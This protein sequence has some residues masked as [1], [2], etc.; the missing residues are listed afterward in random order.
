[1]RP[2]KKIVLLLLFLLIVFNS[3][4][5]VA[6]AQPVAAEKKWSDWVKS[7]LYSLLSL[8]LI[9]VAF[10]I[11]FENRKPSETIAWILAFIL[12]P[13]FGIILYFLIGRNWRK[14]KLFRQ[15]EIVEMEHI[16]EI[17]HT[18]IEAVRS[19]EQ[20]CGGWMTNK[21][22]LL[23]LVLNNTHSPFTVNNRTE[24]LTNGRQTYGAILE[25]IKKAK[26]HIHLEFYIVRDDGIGKQIQQAL[27]ERAKQ[28]VKVRFMYDGLGSW[29]LSSQYVE[30]LKM[31]G[32]QVAAFLPVRIP[33]MNSKLNYRNH[34]K[35][36]VIDGSIGF[37]GG[38]NIGDEYLGLNEKMGFWRDS[39][40]KIEGEAVYFLQNIFLEDWGFIT[41][42]EVEDLEYFPAQEEVGEELIQIAA[43]GPDSDWESIMQA[44]FAT[45][46]SAQEKVY[47][48]SPYF[49]PCESIL[50][51]LKTAALSGVDVRIIL[52]GRPD[53]RIVYWASMSYVEDLLR[54]GVKVYLYEKG[55]IHAKILMVD[56]EVASVGTANM[57]MRSFHHN[58]EVNALIYEHKVVKRLERDFLNDI[59]DSR[60]LTLEE[61]EKRSIWKKS[62]ESAA[63]LFSPLL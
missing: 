27:I 12:S 30:E 10:V 40:L 60:E 20:F 17:I 53:H 1:M 51:A 55:F 36:V 38:L 22:R 16:N 41:G 46:A 49:V 50:M 54:A 57:D 37:V 11:F 44:Y 25:E 33:L 3:L 28:G 39:H 47:I 45:I 62:R 6:S 42:E 19:N 32:V 29:K 26:H 8:S 21:R 35:I 58:F 24:V 7:I 23:Q 52:P 15:K 63:R 4:T 56:S 61:F 59:Q 18:Q 31:A 2:S 5:P 43:S 48:T 34:R 14:K 13:I 9:I